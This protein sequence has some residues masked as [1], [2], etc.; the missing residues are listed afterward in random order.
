M[1]KDFLMRKLLESKLKDVPEA[2]REKLISAISKNPEL[3]QKI[4]E[5]IMS[6]S[7]GKPNMQAAMTVMRKYESQLKDLIGK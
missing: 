6:A 5:E 1:F 2:E 7:G 4:S 3:F